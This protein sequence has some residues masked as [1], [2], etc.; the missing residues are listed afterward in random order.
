MVNVAINDNGKVI[1]EAKLPTSRRLLEDFFNSFTGPVQAVVERASNWYW[2]SDWWPGQ[3]R[4]ADAGSLQD[5]G[6]DQL[7]EGKD[8]QSGCEDLGRAAPGGP[9]SG[10]LSNQTRPAGGLG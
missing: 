6:S 4:R 10:G 2:L 5:G 8:R 7:R 3:R 9:Y 1:S